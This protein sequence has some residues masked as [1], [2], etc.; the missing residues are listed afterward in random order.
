MTGKLPFHVCVT[1][2]LQ[3]NF[4]VLIT[5]HY[6]YLSETGQINI[7]TLKSKV[8]EIRILFIMMT[9]IGYIYSDICIK[10]H[11]VWVTFVYTAH[12]RSF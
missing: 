1:P 4:R 7:P 6:I 2:N 12:H 8:P 10:Q 11:R 3:N 9:V 5:S